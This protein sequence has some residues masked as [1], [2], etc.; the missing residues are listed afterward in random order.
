MIMA[1]KRWLI[2]LTIGLLVMIDGVG[3]IIVY[4][5]QGMLDHSVRIARF[6]AGMILA[7]MGAKFMKGN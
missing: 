3:S 1:S 7:I 4:Y 2:V 5:N 6:F